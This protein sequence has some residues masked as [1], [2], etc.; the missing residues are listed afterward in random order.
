MQCGSITEQIID[1][2]VCLFSFGWNCYCTFGWQ[3]YRSKYIVSHWSIQYTT[4]IIYP[5]LYRSTYVL[6]RC[7]WRLNYR[8]MIFVQA[9]WLWMEDD[10][11]CVNIALQQP[12][13]NLNFQS[14][15]ES[16]SPFLNQQHK[17]FLE[18]IYEPDQISTLC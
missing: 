17:N 4:S 10:V 15:V 3:H 14:N 16:S 2:T 13:K 12:L 6:Y 9:M 11:P 1:N 5:L 7:V 18:E 8:V